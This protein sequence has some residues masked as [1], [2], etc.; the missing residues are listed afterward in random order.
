MNILLGVTGS[1]SAYRA[2]DICYGLI[3]L[4][5]NVKVVL[6]K[7]GLEF[8]N[9]N[10]FRYLGAQAVF[11]PNDDFNTKVY[12]NKEPSSTHIDL[13]KWCDRFIVAPLTANTIANLANGNA[14]DLLTSTFLATY[15]TPIVLFPAMNTHMLNHPMTQNNLERLD[16]LKDVII[17][18]PDQGLLACGDTGK[19]KLPSVENVIDVIVTT[20]NKLNDKKVLITTGA[21]SAPIDPI[22]YLTNPASGITGYHL[23]KEFLLKG[24]ET[25]VIAGADSVKELDYLTKLPH[26]RLTRVNTT[27]QMKDK[28]MAEINDSDLFISSAA[29]CDYEFDISPSKIKKDSTNKTLSYRQSADILKEVLNNKN[30]KLKTVGFAAETEISDSIFKQKWENKPVNLLIGNKVSSG[31]TD[32]TL[33][34]FKV[35]NGEYYFIVDGKIKQ[36]RNLQKTELANIIANWEF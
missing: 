1:I 36:Q 22:R 23:A 11:H 18:E 10:V 26:F 33:E 28:V 34:G 27:N 21:T 12:D 7:G 25:V 3:K 9:P 4:G 8:V 14:F 5:H 16:K 29:V 20:P 19:G 35:S 31:R 15:N 24:Y 30:H 2:H 13:A 17:C 6:T 32:K